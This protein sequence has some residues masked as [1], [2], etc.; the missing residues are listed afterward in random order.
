MAVHV[1]HGRIQRLAEHLHLAGGKLAK[2][3]PDDD[4]LREAAHLAHDLDAPGPL[5]QEPPALE[6]FGGGARNDGSEVRVM[7]RL[8]GELDLPAP[9][10]P[11]VAVDHGE[12]VAE[13]R[14][15]ARGG[16]A[17]G[18]RAGMVL[19]HVP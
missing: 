1:T 10:T 13:E 18:I 19:Q 17:L 6:H 9:M 11:A 2:A 8:K 14:P 4:R 15:H 3:R 7:A 5:G 12:A 16:R